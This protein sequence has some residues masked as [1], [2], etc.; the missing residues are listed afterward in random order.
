[1]LSFLL[2]FSV[3]ENNANKVIFLK[4]R[5]LKRVHLVLPTL[6]GA[7]R[8]GERIPVT[9]LSAQCSITGWWLPTTA[10]LPLHGTCRN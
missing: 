9:A 7:V 5:T 10:P 3:K 4:N 1:M 8:P 6:E 2:C